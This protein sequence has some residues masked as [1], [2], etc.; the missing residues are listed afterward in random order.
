MKLKRSRSRANAKKTLM[1]YFVPIPM[2]ATCSPPAVTVLHLQVAHE[3][4]GISRSGLI[5]LRDSLDSYY[6]VEFSHGGQKYASLDGNLLQ[7]GFI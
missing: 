2:G 3:C 4:V 5:H 6:S 7:N 1:S